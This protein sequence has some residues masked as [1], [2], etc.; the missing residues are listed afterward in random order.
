MTTKRVAKNLLLRDVP[1][2]A[3]RHM[4]DPANRHEAEYIFQS[5]D[6]LRETTNLYSFVIENTSGK[7]ILALSLAYSFPKD[8]TDERSGML[9]NE[10]IQARLINPVSSPLMQPGMKVGYCLALGG[11][12]NFDFKNGIRQIQPDHPLHPQMTDEQ[13]KQM[14]KSTLSRFAG[15]DRL[16]NEADHWGGRD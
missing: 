10:A 12:A 1:G 9:R 2:V 7:A 15:F 16:L 3:L 8:A 4:G 11:Q 14:N 6:E 13:L 5:P